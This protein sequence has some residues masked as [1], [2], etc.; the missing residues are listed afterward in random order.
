MAK[1][2][3][4]HKLTVTVTHDKPVTRAQAVG[5]FR[6]NWCLPG[7]PTEYYPSSDYWG[8]EVGEAKIVAA[9][10]AKEKSRA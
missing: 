9:Q 4:R 6:H 3:K 2:A 5:M 10:S 8:I 1:K 7:F